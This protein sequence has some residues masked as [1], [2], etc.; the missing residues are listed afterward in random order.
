MKRPGRLNFFLTIVFLLVHGCGS[1]GKKTIVAFTPHSSRLS[2]VHT[3]A[4]LSVSEP[5]ERSARS[6]HLGTI[7]DVRN[8]GEILAKKI[9]EKLL[10]SG[11]FNIIERSA[12][13]KVIEEHYLSASDLF[14]KGSAAELG[15]LVGCDSVIIVEVQRAETF[16][17]IQSACYRLL[18]SIRLVETD[19]AEVLMI[20]N[21]DRG[22][23]IE[24]V[25]GNDTCAEVIDKECGTIVDQLIN[26]LE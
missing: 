17:R 10:L 22:R 2:S 25:Y 9:S 20:A 24:G 6:A 23:E 13:K 18:A 16:F 11:K 21:I 15:K 26:K 7:E 12:I 8:P 1:P 5:A 3:I 14:D 4:V 19:T